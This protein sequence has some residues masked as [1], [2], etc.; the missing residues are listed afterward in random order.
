MPPDTDRAGCKIH[1]R[2][3]FGS[4]PFSIG[5]LGPEMTFGE[6]VGSND[7]TLSSQAEF[8][9]LQMVIPSLWE[10]VLMPI[11]QRFTFSQARFCPSV[12]ETLGR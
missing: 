9:K 1:F 11:M 2:V 10:L 7:V 6:W 4:N 5:Y 8:K 3:P 12:S